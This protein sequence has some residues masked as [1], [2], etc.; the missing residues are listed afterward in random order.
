MHQYYILLVIIYAHD[1]LISFDKLYDKLFNYEA[2]LKR[3]LHPS[4]AVSIIVNFIKNINFSNKDKIN[5]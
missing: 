5:N 4:N 1:S 2:Y 3:E